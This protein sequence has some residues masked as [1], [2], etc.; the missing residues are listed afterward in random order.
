MLE[1]MV[2]T[3]T[4][5]KII[6]DYL[7]NKKSIR[8]IEEENPWYGRTKIR[9]I[10]ERYASLSMKNAEQVGLAL[11]SQ[12]QHKEVKHIEE[13]E[14]LSDEQIEKAY[15][16]IIVQR[17]TLTVVAGELKRN[18]ETVKNAIIDYLGDDKISVLEFKNILKEN[19][20]PGSKIVFWNELSDEEKKILIFKMMYDHPTMLSM[21]LNNKIKPVVNTLDNNRDLGKNNTSTILRENPAILGAS[22]ERTK[23]QIKILRDSKTMHFALRKP[24]VFRTSPELMYAQIKLWEKGN[25][26]SSPFVSTKKMYELYGK[27]VNEVQEEFNVEDKYGDDEYFDRI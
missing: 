25:K 15:K 20:N 12:K 23:L 11:Q 26:H 14:E 24:R 16:S 3:E 8:T 1:E 10:I 9:N 5:S 21:S 19:Q 18:R 27:T 13:S 22:L 2:F 4:E 7:K 6:T 17:K